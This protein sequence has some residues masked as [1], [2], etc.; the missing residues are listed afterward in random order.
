MQPV[1]DPAAPDLPAAPA[2]PERGSV[3]GVR[4][5][6]SDGLL[7]VPAEAQRGQQPEYGLRAEVPVEPVSTVRRVAAPLGP[8]RG[9]VLR[10]FE[11]TLIFSLEELHE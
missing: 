5:P 8:V 3:L 1:L 10:P 9:P 7:T 6:V 4:H 2:V 11:T